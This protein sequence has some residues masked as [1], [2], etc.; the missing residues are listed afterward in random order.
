MDC[1]QYYNGDLVSLIALIELFDKCKAKWTQYDIA[2]EFAKRVFRIADFEKRVQVWYKYD[3]LLQCYALDYLNC[4]K[5]FFMDSILSWNVQTNK[6]DVWKIL[7]ANSVAYQTSQP[8]KSGLLLLV[9]LTH[10]VKIHYK[11]WL[12][13]LAEWLCASVVNNDLHLIS[14]L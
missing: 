4:N 14:H 10:A 8:V 6:F 11:C 7:F 1:M 9:A 13:T 12:F 2:T 5:I 3:N